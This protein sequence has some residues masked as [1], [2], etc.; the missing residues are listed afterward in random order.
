[1]KK[2]MW[3]KGLVIGIIILFIG[4]SV[5]P[6]TVDIIGKKTVFTGFNSRGYIQDLIDN[7]SNGDTI[8]IPNGTYYEN[9]IIDKSI[10]LIGEDKNTTIIDGGGWGDVVRIISN[11]VNISDFTIQNSGGGD[12]NWDAGIE[13]YEANNNTILN[14]NIYGPPNAGIKALNVWLRSSNNN[15]V[16]DNIFSNDRYGIVIWDS[17]TN[18]IFN[19]EI[20]NSSYYGISLSQSSYN[21]Q[22]YH[23]NFIHNANSSWDE[24]DNFWDN[25]YPSGGNYWDDFDEPS[26]GAWD[27]NSDGIVDSP[28]NIPGDSNQDNYPLMYP[29]YPAHPDTV[30]VD[31]D[32]N[33]S[34]PG[35][36]YDRF[37]RI[38]YGI[39]EV[40][41]S[42]VYV[43]NGMYYENVVIDKTINLIG[44]DKNN[45]II[46]SAGYA[47][48][49]YIAI[50]ADWVNITGFTIKNAEYN[51]NGIGVRSNFNSIV[52]N[53]IVSNDYFGVYFYD[54]N[55]N[56]ISDNNISENGAQ[57]I[58]IEQS[59]YNIISDNEIKENID[60]GINLNSHAYSNNISGNIIKNNNDNGIQLYDSCDNNNISDN[61]ITDSGDEG[62]FLYDSSNNIIS[63]NDVNSVPVS[64]IGI[65][66]DYSNYNNILTNVVSNNYHGIEFQRS[67]NNFIIG[68][69]LISN[70]NSGVWLRYSSNN[71]EVYHN[72][73]INNT[74]GENPNAVDECSNAWHNGYPSGG[75]YW[76][77][78]DEPSEGAYDNFSG[79]HQ[80]ISDPDYIVDTPYP[81]PGG[82]NQDS[83]PFME[84]YGWIN[85]APDIPERPSGEFIVGSGIECKYTT[86]TIDP[87]NDPVWYMW[88]WGDGSYSDWLGPYESGEN[89]SAKQ[90]WSAKRINIRVKAKDIRNP[91][92]EWSEPLEVVIINPESLK[93]VILLGTIANLRVSSNY[94]M[95]NAIKLLWIS[96]RPPAFELLTSLQTIVISNEKIG[97]IWDPFIC[98]IFNAMELKY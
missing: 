74:W 90:S 4:A 41:G 53:N 51:C 84:P 12:E 78:F 80:N 59:S 76:S 65:F 86:S 77:D 88:D 21:N 38:Q 47:D 8:Y 98:G 45:T 40:E 39:N 87:D 13:V 25:G 58:R 24:C 15:I 20:Y 66:L 69:N 35:W 73:F 28:Y 19:N 67:N 31:D 33:N 32:Y 97:I 46:S 9:I 60:D 1:M 71:N 11:W 55:N 26:E 42:T 91:E 95:F 48:V 30:Y 17:N 3:K 75:N 64:T 37:N 22:I 14:N 29:W 52:G 27:N 57:G 10:S 5:I 61:T 81:I 79:P 93:T 16:S 18:I 62:I 89:A 23:N 92:T 36:G 7:A 94:S 68:N 72:N 44:E 54:S 82:S 43:Y 49:V 96:F 50:S 70:N 83:Y 63:R 56:I 34:T 85:S 2:S 6:L